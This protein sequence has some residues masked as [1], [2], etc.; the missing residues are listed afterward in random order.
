[1]RR[2]YTRTTVLDWLVRDAEFPQV[3]T[4]HLRLN[5]NLVECLSVVHTDDAA[6]HL[7][8]YDHVSQ[9]CLDARRLLKSWR[10]FLCFTQPLQERHRFPLEPSRE[11]TSN[12][13]VK[14]LHQLLICHVKKLIQVDSSKSVLPKC[15]LLLLLSQLRCIHIGHLFV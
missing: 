14:Q 4:N 10:L 1:M 12:S 7:R 11:T 2:S 15:P 13:S 5:F 9:M 8:D 6:D 3:V